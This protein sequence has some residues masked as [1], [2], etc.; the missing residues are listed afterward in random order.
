M[1]FLCATGTN[2]L[3]CDSFFFGLASH[4]NKCWFLYGT[5]AAEA[6][7]QIETNNHTKI[8]QTRIMNHEYSVFFGFHKNNRIAISNF[9][10]FSFFVPFNKTTH[11]Y[12]C[13]RENALDAKE[14]SQT[15][16][17]L[18]N[19]MYNVQSEVVSV[20]Q[21]SNRVIESCN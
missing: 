15:E 4:C 8:V 3:D 9:F 19:T 12:K 21:Q 17:L 11:K 7:L 20:P 16:M 13:E 2:R 5:V 6:L 18:I 1:C 10:L 14:Q